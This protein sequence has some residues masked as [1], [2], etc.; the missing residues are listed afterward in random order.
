MARVP[1]FCFIAFGFWVYF[2]PIALFK[3]IDSSH[4]YFWI[5]MLS[6]IYDVSVPSH[7]SQ[8]REKIRNEGKHGNP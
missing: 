2:G 1:M 7:L 6:C 8:R 4:I 5:L 3:N